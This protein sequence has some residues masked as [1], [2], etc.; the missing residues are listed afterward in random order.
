MIDRLTQDIR[1]TVARLLTA[2]D[3][4][5]AS[6]GTWENWEHD[7]F[8][9]TA[10]VS[11]TYAY[12]MV[13]SKDS[14]LGVIAWEGGDGDAPFFAEPTSRFRPADAARAILDH[15]KAV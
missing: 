5:L 8:F 9:L 13:I 4:H 14:Q 1:M 15:A 2:H 3:A 7:R 11:E 6:G 10:E 12:Q